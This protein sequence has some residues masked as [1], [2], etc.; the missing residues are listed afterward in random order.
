M[1]Q[2]FN[3]PTRPGADVDS[4]LRSL[5]NVKDAIGFFERNNPNSPELSLLVS[6]YK[7][8]QWTRTKETR[9]TDNDTNNIIRNN[10][11]H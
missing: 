7:N 1:H 5:E 9:T 4:Y 2:C 11:K 10:A 8:C 6:V 3:V